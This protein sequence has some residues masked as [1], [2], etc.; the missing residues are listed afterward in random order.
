MALPQVSAHALGAPT[1]LVVGDLILDRYVVGTV[2][3]V[4]PEAPIQVLR[5]EDSYE[6]LGGMGS[7]ARNLARLGARV[8]LASLVGDDAEGRRHS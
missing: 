5:E 3:R 6:R 7:V 4:S 8:R 1:L 2:E